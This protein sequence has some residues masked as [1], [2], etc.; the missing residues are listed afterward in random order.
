VRRA[1]PRRFVT[2]AT[3]FLDS[4]DSMAGCPRPHSMPRLMRSWPGGSGRVLM[5][6]PARFET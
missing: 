2:P 5:S 3:N 6:K 1:H 4:A